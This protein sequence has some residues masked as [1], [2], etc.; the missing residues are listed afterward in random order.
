MAPS[1]V[2]GTK[3]T[4]GFNQTRNCDGD[5]PGGVNVMISIHTLS[6][7]YILAKLDYIIISHS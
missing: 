7:H 4:T 1:T 2:K 3:F 5:R 6:S